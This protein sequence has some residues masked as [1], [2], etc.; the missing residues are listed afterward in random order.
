[1]SD[2]AKSIAGHE[3]RN[4]ELIARLLESGESLID[5]RVCD[6]FFCAP[7]REL[8]STLARD[9]QEIGLRT[10]TVMQPGPRESTWLVQ[11]ELESSVQHVASAG[12]T[13]EMVQVAGRH[14]SEYDGWGTELS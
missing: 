2:E 7:T 3:A 13:I 9:L 12:F 4:R 1:M 8:A 5:V 14:G 11:C 10:I 6:L